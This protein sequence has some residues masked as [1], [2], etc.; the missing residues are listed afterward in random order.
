MDAELGPGI[1]RAQEKQ[2]GVKRRWAEQVMTTAETAY[3][4][5]PRG[6]GCDGV[7]DDRV[8]TEFGHDVDEGFDHVGVR[9]GRRVLDQVQR[10]APRARPD[11]SP[12]L[13]E[14]I[15]QAGDIALLERVPDLVDADV[16]RALESVVH[17]DQERRV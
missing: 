14:W 16:R 8:G 1:G 9:A 2:P 15:A 3:V 7:L 6:D 4:G 11:L 13:A 5:E 12:K 10:G 17:R